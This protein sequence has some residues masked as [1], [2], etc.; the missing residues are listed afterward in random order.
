MTV[1]PI[2]NKVLA[3]VAD[4]EIQYEITDTNGNG[5]KQLDGINYHLSV[6][7]PSDATLKGKTLNKNQQI[8]LNNIK[9]Q[10]NG[11]VVVDAN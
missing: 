3:G 5:L 9:L 6:T 11:K 7:A 8:I 1:T 2:K 10:L 4:G